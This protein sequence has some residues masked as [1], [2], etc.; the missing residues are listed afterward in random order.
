MAHLAWGLLCLAAAVVA[1]STLHGWVL[2]AVVLGLVAGHGAGAPLLFQ[3]Q[4]R[5]LLGPLDPD[6]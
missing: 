1:L 4:L 2:V 6:L 3:R 5:G